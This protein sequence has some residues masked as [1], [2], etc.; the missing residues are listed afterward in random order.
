MRIQ[1]LPLTPLV[2]DGASRTPFVV[3][4]DRLS[5]Q[6]R[7]HLSPYVTEWMK[8]SFG[9]AA[10]IVSGDEDIEIS[11]QLDLPDDLRQQ[12]LEQIAATTDGAA[13]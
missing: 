9:A 8:E 1:I 5:S 3:V 10:V 13:I 2:V 11:P 4:L 7:E 12:L 6:E